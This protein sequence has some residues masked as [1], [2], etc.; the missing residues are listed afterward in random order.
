MVLLPCTVLVLQATLY[1]LDKMDLEAA[2]E[3]DTGKA[4]TAEAEATA[5]AGDDSSANQREPSNDENSKRHAPVPRR[6][7]I[8][9]SR[10]YVH[11]GQISLQLQLYRSCRLFP[12]QSHKP[13]HWVIAY[14]S[15]GSQ[16]VQTESVTYQSE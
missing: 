15:Q 16:Q 14:C 7:A 12:C 5:G 3:N 6:H 1:M 10:C 2:M 11:G 9:S 4:A 13:P 8:G